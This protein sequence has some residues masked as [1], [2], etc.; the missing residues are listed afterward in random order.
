MELPIKGRK[1][2]TGGEILS[3]DPELA[4]T[5]GSSVHMKSTALDRS[6]DSSC[7]DRR[8]STRSRRV[9]VVARTH[10]HSES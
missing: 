1:I 7:Q 2:I 3:D 9:G 8:S 6:P 10:G 4:R 5:E